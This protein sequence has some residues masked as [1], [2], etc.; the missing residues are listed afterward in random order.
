M[1][2]RKTIDISWLD[3]ACAASYLFR[4]SPTTHGS[5][6]PS[7]DCELAP[8]STY[9]LSVR[10][11][12]DLWLSAVDFSADSEILF[13]A[14]TIGDMPNI[15][16]SHNLVPIPVDFTNESSVDIASLER[17]ITPR[18]R[19]I[20][21]A[22]LFGAVMP[23]QQIID[24]ARRHNLLVFE[25]CAQAFQNTNYHG[26]PKSDLVA[27]S[28]GPIK[29]ATALGGCLFH[30]RDPDII[31][32]MESI[33]QSYPIQKRSDFA[34]R[35][36]KY[37]LLKL[38]A[39]RLPL[40]IFHFICNRSRKDIDQQLGGLARNFAKGKLV[41]R[42]RVQP[43]APLVRLLDR[44]I[45]RF[46]DDH[47][48]RRIELA[49]LFAAQCGNPE[50]LACHA[51]RRRTFWVLAVKSKQPDSL[52]AAMRENGFD[53]T[54]RS[55]MVVVQPPPGSAPAPNAESTLDQLVFLPLH[56]R[57][58]SAEV[59]RMAKVVR[60]LDN[61]GP[62]TRPG[63]SSVAELVKSSEASTEVLTTSATNSRQ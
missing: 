30:V 19:A 52:V 3:L 62:V 53:A 28:F 61:H 1:W 24:V 34:R 20:V 23:M 39:C 40:A 15:A 29:T 12:F 59:I 8:D 35:I 7:V 17:A 22:H 46:S 6:R 47:Q 31:A 56:T 27:F 45:S 2:A 48:S 57:M 60:E 11:C 50:L 10:T 36:L 5:P 51:S 41:N 18:T 16:Q 42:L 9:C 25:D 63:I 13:S 38:L 55:S 32:T 4:G 33:H 43:G 26:H 44:R 54:R 58:R 37:S 14:I 49:L 21:V